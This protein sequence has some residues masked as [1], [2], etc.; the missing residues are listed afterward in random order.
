M[1]AEKAQLKR[2]CE[3]IEKSFQAKIADVKAQSAPLERRY[4]E[5]TKV[6]VNAKEME[7][8]ATKESKEQATIAKEVEQLFTKML[9]NILNN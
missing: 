5:L 6:L 2:T 8:A 7:T 4:Q 3:N 1:V 9:F